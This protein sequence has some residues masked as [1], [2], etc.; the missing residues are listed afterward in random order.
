M[1][2]KVVRRAENRQY[3]HFLAI[4]QGSLIIKPL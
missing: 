4:E 2:E 3:Q 1:G